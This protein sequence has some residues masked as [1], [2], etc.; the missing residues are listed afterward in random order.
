MSKY[1]NVTLIRSEFPGRGELLPYYYMHKLHLFDK[2]YIL[3]DSIFIQKK[4]PH[5]SGNFKL[6]WTAGHF[7]NIKEEDLFLIEKLS[8]SNDM[9]AFYKEE[10]KWKMC[11]GVM[12]FVSFEALT[13]I[14]NEYNF[15]NLLN[16]VISRQH[17]CSLERVYA[18]CLYHYYQNDEKEK[19]SM[20]PQ[21][22]DIHKYIGWGTSYKNIMRNPEIYSKLDLIKVWTGR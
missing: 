5:Q 13:N 7:C 10:S 8:K 14:Q 9:E 2:A 3:H 17:R 18:L 21:F 11:F 12:S 16:F 15:F 6:L 1:E 4:L 20:I 19:D 22:G